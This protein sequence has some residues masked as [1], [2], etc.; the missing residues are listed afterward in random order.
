MA[1]AHS[2]LTHE[3]LL[4]LLDYDRETGAFRWKQKVRGVRHKGV[5]EMAGTSKDREKYRRIRIDGRVYYGHR[6]AWFYVHGEWPPAG[7]DHKDGLS[8]RIENLRPASQAQNTRNCRKRSNNTS[9]FKGVL[10]RDR[11]H[12]HRGVQWIATIHVNGKRVHVGSR[13]TAEEAA[14]AYD[15]AAIRLHGEFAKTNAMLGLL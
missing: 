7:I 12:E 9:G 11:R 5:G 15:E 6:L 14:R 8:D 2:T 13:K 3:R 1:A 10:M 4:T